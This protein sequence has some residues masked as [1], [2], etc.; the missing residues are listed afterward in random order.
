MH[1]L[2]WVLQGQGLLKRYRPVTASPSYLYPM[3][4]SSEYV[5]TGK[6]NELSAK[7]SKPVGL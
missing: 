5:L 4:V 7:G 1:V 3:L 6:E 2:G